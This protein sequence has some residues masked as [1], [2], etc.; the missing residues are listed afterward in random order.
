M[1]IYAYM[2]YLLLG[3]VYLSV[4]LGKVK[5]IFMYGVETFIFPWSWIFVGIWWRLYAGKMV[6]RNNEKFQGNATWFKPLRNY[7]H[8]YNKNMTSYESVNMRIIICK[9]RRF[10][11]IGDAYLYKL[12]KKYVL[13]V[14]P[15]E[16]KSQWNTEIIQLVPIA[17]LVLWWTDKSYLLACSISPFCYFTHFNTFIILLAILHFPNNP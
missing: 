12:N 7:Y 11:T 8:E 3:K 15:E 9:E 13:I 1:Y 16:T 2:H 17:R 10:F 14:I 5:F 4:E 6:I